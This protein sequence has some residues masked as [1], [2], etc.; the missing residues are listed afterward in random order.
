MLELETLKKLFKKRYDSH[1]NL[2][3]KTENLKESL[4]HPYYINT[5]NIHSPIIL[6][7]ST[8]RMSILN[9]GEIVNDKKFYNSKFLYPIGFSCKRKYRSFKNDNKIFYLL[10][11]TKSGINIEAENQIFKEWKEFVQ[12]FDN[13]KKSDNNLENSNQEDKQPEKL[14]TFS[15]P[16]KLDGM[17]FEEFFGFTNIQL[18]K[19]LE[20]KMNLKFKDGIEGYEG[21]QS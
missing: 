16:D 21:F 18:Q 12:K 14:P 1:L 3:K 10:T 6:G 20:Q 2:L 9:L 8:T 19:M 17:S 13:L 7:S 11:I 5:N 15:T 4:F